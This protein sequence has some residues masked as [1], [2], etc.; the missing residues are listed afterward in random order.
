MN[1]LHGILFPEMAEIRKQVRE[2]VQPDIDNIK[3]ELSIA[4]TQVVIGYTL[5]IGILLWRTKK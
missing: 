3:K 5:L 4:K 1:E 2:E